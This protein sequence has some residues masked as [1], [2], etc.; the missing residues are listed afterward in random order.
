[1]F[2]N[3]KESP[4]CKSNSYI[5]NDSKLIHILLTF[6]Q[7]LFCQQLLLLALIWNCS[8]Y[9]IH[10]FLHTSWAERCAEDFLWLLIVINNSGLPDKNLPD[11][12]DNGKGN[13]HTDAEPNAQ[14]SPHVTMQFV[15]ETCSR[16][17]F[18]HLLAKRS[19]LLN[20]I[21]FTMSNY[22]DKSARCM[23][24]CMGAKANTWHRKHVELCWT[25]GLIWTCATGCLRPIP[26]TYR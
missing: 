21:R 11:S 20:L 5:S 19:P 9:P 14:E 23:F 6:H 1:M 24:V 10:L 8:P 3:N 18:Y 26:L 16:K 13:S 15:C 25:D 7:V 12:A 17:G 4:T 2:A 22:T